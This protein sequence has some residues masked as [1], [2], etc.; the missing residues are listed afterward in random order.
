MSVGDKHM[1]M[2]LRISLVRVAQGAIR[3]GHDRYHQIEA[4]LRLLGLSSES[5]YE[6]IRQ[7]ADKIDGGWNVLAEG[8]AQAL[9]PRS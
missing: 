3:G 7:H 8:I 6:T 2:S 1:L 4:R 9:E 5:S